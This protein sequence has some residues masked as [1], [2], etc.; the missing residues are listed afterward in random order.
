MSV[1]ESRVIED[2][3]SGATAGTERILAEM[4]AGVLRVDRVPVDSHFFDELGADSLVMAHFCARLRKRG[5]LPSVSM[6]DVYAHP[7]IRRLAAAVGD[8]AAAPAR[9]AAAAVLE[10][11]TPTSARE[12]VLCGVWQVLFY[13][14]YS[15]L[16]VL[17]AVEGYEWMVA[18]SQG[19]VGYLRVVRFSAVAFLVVCAVPIAA[20]WLLI[21]RWKPQQIRIWSFDY[22]RFWIVKTLIKSNPGV[23]LLVGSPLYGLYLKALGAN[24]GPGVVI[25][26][27]RIPVCTDLLTIGAGTVIRREAIFLGYRARAGRIEIG[28]VTLGRNAYVGEATV[29]DIDTAVGDGAQVGHSSALLTGQ[30]VPAGERWHGSPAQR[31]ETNYVRVAPTRCGRLRRTAYAAFALI[32]I[33]FLWAP[34]LEGGLGLLLL[35]V[36]ALVEV[37][38][39]SVQSST[40]ALTIRGLFIEA[41]VF[42][43]VLFF[44]AVLAGLLAVGTVP[45]ILHRFIKPGT[46]YPLYG[47]QYGLHRVIAR[48]GRMEFL[49]LLFGDSSFIVHYLSWTGCRLA[50]VVQT[51]SNFGSEV[52]TS[53]PLLT[54]VGSGTMVADGL[55]VVNEDVSSTSFRVSRAAI[56]SRNFIGNDVTY[57]AGAATGDNCLL[58]VKVMV[59]LDGRVRKGVGLLGSPP[60]EIP[61]SVERDSQFDHL[62]TGDALRRRLAAKNWFNLQTIGIFLFT[63]WFGVFLITV[64]DLTALEFFYG[65]LAHTIMAA[66]FALSAVVAAVY[67]ASVEGAF[68]A[69]SPPP[70]AICSIYDRRFWW[71]ERIWKLHPFHFL[72]IFNGTPFKNVLWRLIGVR[73]GTRVF[74][75][76]VYISEPTLTAIG[77]ECVFNERSKIQCESQEDGTY[78]SGRTTLGAG[79]TVGVGAFVHYG[80]TM[81]DGS[82][83]AADSFLM[84]GEHVP[85]RARWG[86]NP[87]REM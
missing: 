23:Y 86:G 32:G 6:K 3:P 54:S 5:D 60:F 2:R 20:K 69:L 68:E 7:T 57:P 12:Y 36:S 40:G 22:V 18:G 26:S 52:I 25:L 50:P 76:G 38:D 34:L 65:V 13:L 10:L 56:G 27:R 15:Y 24:I 41:L 1:A 43:V 19:V 9:P 30:S 75:D 47:F 16:G 46:V 17:A 81:R 29:L 84:K 51:G 21:G 77:D 49:T 45:R 33:L 83:L 4:L 79:C 28:R 61:R 53:D 64:I 70:P 87:A 14:G 11:P 55:S 58:A 71:V 63:R 85:P 42:S 72:H 66:L 31:T 74:D 37:F 35:G 59:P 62:R 39:P 67:Y 80:V 78:K 73:I 82:V 48:L 8:L 44:G